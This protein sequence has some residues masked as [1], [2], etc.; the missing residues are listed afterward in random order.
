MA[1]TKNAVLSVTPEPSGQAEEWLHYQQYLQELIDR[2]APLMQ[3]QPP[4][5]AFAHWIR[6]ASLNLI[7]AKGDAANV[8]LYFQDAAVRKRFELRVTKRGI[9]EQCKSTPECGPPKRRKRGPQKSPQLARTRE[10]LPRD[11]DSDGRLELIARVARKS[12]RNSVM[13]LREPKDG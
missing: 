1:D 8:A 5:T 13:T 9:G 10:R 4:V 12:R 11:R 3:M 7:R 2:L 6:K